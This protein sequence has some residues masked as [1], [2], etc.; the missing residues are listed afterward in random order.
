MEKY[1]KLPVYYYYSHYLKAIYNDTAHVNVEQ[2]IA[3]QCRQI[4]YLVNDSLSPSNILLTYFQFLKLIE[5]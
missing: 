5:L 4:W 2:S 1:D 3:Q